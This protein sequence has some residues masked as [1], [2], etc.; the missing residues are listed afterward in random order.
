MFPV[1]LDGMIAV[2]LVGIL[3]ALFFAW[4]AAADDLRHEVAHRVEIGEFLCLFA[5]HIHG[6]LVW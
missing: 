2:Y 3:C 1:T 6:P 4:L 5:I